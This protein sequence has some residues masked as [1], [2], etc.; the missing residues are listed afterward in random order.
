MSHRLNRARLRRT[1]L[2]AA[3]GMCLASTAM[4]QSNTAGAVFG[5]ALPGAQIT[6]TSEATGFTRTITASS[7]GSYRIPALPP[8]NYQV[9]LTRADG[10]TEVR[11]ISVNVGTGSEVD[12]VDETGGAITLDRIQVVGR[13]V[14]PIDVSSVEVTTV[15]TESQI[16]RLPVERNVTDV[17]LLAPGTTQGDGA[18]GNLASFGGASVAENVYYVNGFNVTNILKGTSFSQLPFEAIAEQQIKTGGFGAEFGRSLGGV[19]NLITKRGSNEWHFGG[20]IFWQPSALTEGVRTRSEPAPSKD[21]RV[22]SFDPEFSSMLYNAYASG[23]LLKDRLFFFGLF[24][25]RNFESDN[26]GISTSS[27][28]ESSTPQGVV[29]LDWQITDNHLLEVTGFRDETE[30]V[31]QSFTSA[32]P[33]QETHGTLRGTDTSTNGGDNW[34]G[35]WT[36]YLTDNFTMSALYGE[37]TYKRNQ[38]NSASDCPVVADSR[39]GTQVLLG[40][41]VSQVLGRPD[42]F[43]ERTAYRVD[44]DWLWGDHNIR[45]GLDHEVVTTV[46]GSVY[47]GDVTYIY[48]LVT[49]GQEIE[50]VGIVPAG[51]TEAVSARTFRNGGEF[52]TELDAWYIE[53]S[54]Q[55]TDNFIAKLG[56]RNESFSNLNANGE[57]FVK[58]DNTWAPR[59]GFS[60]DVNGDSSLKVYGN[61]GRYFIPVYSNT[62]VRLAGAELDYT[63]WFSYTGI[64]PETGAPI[65]PTQI[66]GRNTISNGV[67]PD[68]RTVVDGDLDPLYQDE[69]ILGFQ[70]QL[71]DL[72]SVGVSYIH[73]DL[74]SAVDDICD[75]SQAEIWALDNGYDA[76]EANAIYNALAHCFL[77]NPGEDLAANVDLHGTG[78]LTEVLIP[79]D[80]IGIPG[81]VRKY[82]ALEF[83]GERAWDGVWSLKGSYTY[84]RNEGNTEGYVKSDNGQ[85]DAGITQ[86]FDFP[87]LMD[88]A[89]GPLPNERRHTLK[90]FG[91]YQLT[92]EWRIGGFFL[93]KSG[94]PQNCFGV[95]PGDGPD[96]IAPF[97]GVASFYCD[98]QG[99]D[100]PVGDDD[101]EQG[102]PDK[103]APRGSAGRTPWIY[104]LDLQVAYEPNWV[105]GLTFRMDIQNIFNSKKWT[106]VNENFEFRSRQ[107]SN[108]YLHPTAYQEPRSV[109]FSVEYDF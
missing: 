62:N 20:N 8:G 28:V 42:A 36:G 61:A 39:S 14:N 70:K 34:V 91:A 85:D 101:Y 54:W 18:F 48:Q 51:V 6:V 41:W 22:E 40:C 102:F 108:T 81:P 78:E 55:V 32:E 79:A 31:T 46:D 15:L 7:D 99:S 1:A 53:D 27:H 82:R 93:A 5:D 17:A 105:E 68:P 77:T 56:V 38:V 86:D 30:V 74:G 75:G 35:K 13:A 109:I 98:T 12:F 52:E 16:D 23:P 66:G 25:G 3:L 76:D 69:Y 88:G 80:A 95:Y 29:K 58:I 90:L 64:D 2:S 97:Y 96:F 21:Y 92:D 50:G 33:F 4:A 107:P 87:G 9:T 49:P 37:G 65:N 57:S 89:Y 106:E 84:A 26:Y 67:T 24:Q 11:E 100:Q 63:E 45:F 10:S 19:V 60:W 71:G 44:A 72:F 47:S 83:T 59:L 43:D 103:L 94:R 104:Q 73:R